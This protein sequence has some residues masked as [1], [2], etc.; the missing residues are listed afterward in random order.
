[1][2][3]SNV[4]MD[5]SGPKQPAGDVS[6]TANEALEDEKLKSFEDGYSA[7]WDDAM[8]AQEE[9]GRKL[10]A[11]L[12]EAVADATATKEEAFSAF[13]EVNTA[14]VSAL[15]DLVFPK[16]AAEILSAQTIDLIAKYNMDEN[17]VGTQLLVSH[18]QREVFS[19]FVT[20]QKLD[21]INVVASDEVCSDQV[22]IKF[23]NQ[24]KQLDFNE[25][26]AELRSLCSHIL[27]TTKE[28]S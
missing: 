15:L 6:S 23:V 19:N 9:R 28:G 7:G 5:F 26:L 24:E 13:S 17:D 11:A 8:K 2:Q 10:S 12:H 20:E 3:F 1:M 4:L 14:F 21:G 22:V 25:L 18:E 27:E 16:L